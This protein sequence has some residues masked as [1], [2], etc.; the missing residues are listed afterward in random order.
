ML[1]RLFAALALLPLLSLPTWSQ[2][3]SEGAIFLTGDAVWPGAGRIYWLNARSTDD[4]VNLRGNVPHARIGPAKIATPYRALYVSRSATVGTIHVDGIDARV[5]DGCIRAHA[6]RVVVRRTSCSMVRGP[7][8]GR[9]NMP[10]GLQI[11]SAR[12]VIVEDSS[13]DGFLW[14]APGDRYWNGD[15][16]TIE[17][18]VQAARFDRV[19]ANGNTDA[20]FDVR[21]HAIMSD[22]SAADNCRNFRFWSGGDV[23]TL[24]TGDTIKRGGTSSCSGIW[25]NGAASGPPPA[26]HIRK[27]VVRMR[28]PGLIFEVETG[29]ADI[30]VD[31][32]D[33]EAPAG[34]QMIRFENGRGE[35][36]LGR[37][38]TLPASAR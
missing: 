30:R 31:E 23:D 6:D 8:S 21:P 33:I 13:F 20:G 19:S 10:F 1:G 9:V 25:L 17:N 32:C 4:L 36:H 24:T 5:T 38:C 35:L 27:L 12:Q 28:K 11:T 3:R 15:G 26:L 18:D 14:R 37:S 16:V 2:P 29:P 22:V 34:T 7:Q